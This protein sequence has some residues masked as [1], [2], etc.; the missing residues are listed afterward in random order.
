MK[1]LLFTSLIIVML[2]SSSQS[3]AIQTTWGVKAGDKI[4]YWLDSLYFSTT[5][6]ANLAAILSDA[7]RTSFVLVNSVVNNVLNYSLVF[8]NG[9]NVL[10]NQTVSVQPVNL[11]GND[12][13]IPMGSLPLILPLSVTGYSNY[14]QYLSSTTTALGSLFTNI[15]GGSSNNITLNLEGKVDKTFNLLGSISIANLTLLNTLS[16]TGFNFTQ[17]ANFGNMTLNNITSS[18]DVKYNITD[19]SLQDLNMSFTSDASIKVNQTDISTGNVNG[20]MHIERQA[21]DLSSGTVTQNNFQ[22]IQLLWFIP[23][24]L[25]IYLVSRR[26]R[27]KNA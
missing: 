15:F 16:I 14:F 13:M 11:A 2:L 24:P 4:T 26:I 20:S 22:L 27:I 23:V 1:K 19:G 21:I 25:I 3:F 5:G 9:T 10:N 7:N 17:F 12:F 18:I 6:D 8:T